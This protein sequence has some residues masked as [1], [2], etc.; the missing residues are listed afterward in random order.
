MVKL[1]TTPIAVVIRPSTIAIS[2]QV[3]LI[4]PSAMLIA[5]LKGIPLTIQ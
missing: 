2:F 3:S 4:I 5:S 1:K